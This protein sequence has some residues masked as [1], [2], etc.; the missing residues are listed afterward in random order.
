MSNCAAAG[1]GIHIV[2]AIPIHI[3]FSIWLPYDLVIGSHMILTLVQLNLIIGAK[4]IFE[5][6]KID[7]DQPA[8]GK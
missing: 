3:N 2:W 1:V 4:Q 6:A 7:C 5:T 8:I